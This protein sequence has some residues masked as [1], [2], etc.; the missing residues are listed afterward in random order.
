[1]PVGKPLELKMLSPPVPPAVVMTPLKP[2]APTVHLVALSAP[3][4]GAALMVML[5]DP[6]HCAGGP[7]SVVEG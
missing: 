4:D 3:T 5:N 1:M 7:M 2:A 6:G